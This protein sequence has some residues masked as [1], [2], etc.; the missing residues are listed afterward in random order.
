MLG[1]A[2]A[3]VLGGTLLGVGTSTILAA[4]G[5]GGLFLFALVRAAQLGRTGSLL[6]YELQNLVAMALGAAAAIPMA[7]IFGEDV[8]LML[9]LLWGVTSVLGGGLVWWLGREARPDDE[10]DGQ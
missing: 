1:G 9:M 10:G 7:G 8:A 2:V 4:I 3:G 6:E 5:V